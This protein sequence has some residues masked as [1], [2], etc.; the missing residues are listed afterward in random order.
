LQEAIRLITHSNTAKC[1]RNR[2]RLIKGYRAISFI[3]RQA[4]KMV[5]LGK[6]G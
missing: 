2:L 5:G 6:F 4:G 1:Y 3:Q